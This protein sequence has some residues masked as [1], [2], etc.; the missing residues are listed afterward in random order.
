MLHT[1]IKKKTQTEHF[2]LSRAGTKASAHSALHISPIFTF[3]SFS[4][5]W[6][7]FFQYHENKVLFPKISPLATFEKIAATE[8]KN[9]AT[10]KQTCNY[11]C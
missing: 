1:S 10:F 9:K 7:V 5:M 3:Q 6:E 2:K 4:F 8:N 11:K